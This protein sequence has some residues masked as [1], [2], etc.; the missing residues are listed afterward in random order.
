MGIGATALFFIFR[1]FGREG[2]GGSRHMAVI[3]GLIVFLAVCCA[4]L[5]ALSYR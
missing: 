2:A 3:G 4:L 5:F 1:A